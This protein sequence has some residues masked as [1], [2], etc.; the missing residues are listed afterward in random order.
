MIVIKDKDNQVTGIISHGDPSV[1]VEYVAN[2]PDNAELVE[3]FTT[4]E[5]EDFIVKGSKCFEVSNGKLVL[6]A[7][8]Q[9]HARQRQARPVSVNQFKLLFTSAERVAIKQSTDPT[10]EDFYDLI[11]DPRTT[12]VDTSVQSVADAVMYLEAVAQILGAGRAQ[13]ILDA[14]K[15]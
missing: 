7:D 3:S 11:Q 8:W 10:V 2:T 14:C 13:E 15:A 4:E 6:K 12:T 5:V 9:A 1:D